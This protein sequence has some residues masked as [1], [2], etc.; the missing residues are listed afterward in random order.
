MSAETIAAAAILL[1]C[2]FLGFCIGVATRD[3]YD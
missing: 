1:I 3:N 2:F